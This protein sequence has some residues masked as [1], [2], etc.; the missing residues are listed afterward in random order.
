MEIWKPAHK[1]PGYECCSDGRIRNIRTQRVQKPFSD[2][3][4]RM[5]VSLY[6]DRKRYNVKPKRIVAET[7]LGEHPGMEVR[8]RDGDRTN[9]A[10]SNLE[11]FRRHAR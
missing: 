2:K 10:V 8:L 7:F 6:K 5:K 4:G 11:W 3:K 9:T 1:F